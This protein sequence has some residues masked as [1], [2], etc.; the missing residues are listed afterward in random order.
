MAWQRTVVLDVF[1]GSHLAES[2]DT[3]VHELCESHV[4]CIGNP[5]IAKCESVPLVACRAGA[6]S[7]EEGA[8]DSKS[9][10]TL[11]A[12]RWVHSLY[13][14]CRG[15]GTVETA[16]PPGKNSSASTTAQL[17]PMLTGA[18]C[19]V[20]TSVPYCFVETSAR[21]RAAAR[22]APARRAHPAGCDSDARSLASC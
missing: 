20:A 8:R 10:S 7:R 11:A 4:H 3:E 5:R 1:A 16:P 9:D 15:D 22:R 2:R 6:R 21:P 12:A 17:R 19:F 18:D 14:C 13:S